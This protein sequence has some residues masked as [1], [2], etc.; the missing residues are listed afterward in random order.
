M[1]G[2][3]MADS[4]MIGD[5]PA[6]PGRGPSRRAMLRMAI[7][8]L[9]GVSANAFA[10]A[11]PAAA[12]D[13]QPTYPISGEAVTTAER[14][15]AF[16]YDLTGLSAADLQKVAQYDQF[17]YGRW[18]FGAPLPVVARAD[19]LPGG[20]AL[21]MPR[22]KTKLLRFFTFTDVHITDKE[23]PNQL[24]DLQRV[25]PAAHA[26]TS[27]YSPVMLY[28]TQVLDA[29]VQTVNAL[30]QEAPFDFGIV[31]GDVCNSASYKELRWFIDVM[32]GKKITPSSG[33]HAGAETVDYQMAFNAAG[34][35]RSIPWYQVLGNHDHFYI[36]SIPVDARPE[37]GIRESYVADT[38]WAVGDIL[39][40]DL[41]GFP[42]LFSA[43]NLAKGPRIYPGVV[44]GTSPD[45][46][47]IHAGSTEDAAFSGT[48][49]KVTPDPERRHIDRTG[50]MA[51][52]FN[53]E[54]GPRGHGFHL[55][56]QSG[57]AAAEDGFACYSF[58]PDP[59]IPLKVIVLGDTQREDD[60]SLD[61]HGHGYLDRTRWAW[62]KTELEQGQA[63]DQLMIVAAHIP[64]GVSGIGSETEWWAETAGIAPELRNAVSLQE[65]VSAL[66]AAPN[67]IAWISGHRHLNTV[68]AFVS[69]DASR[70]EMGFWQVETS[71][72]R[73]FPQQFRT[74]DILLNDD[75]TISI[76]TLNVDPAVAEGSP[77]ATSRSR[78]V[79]VQQIV[80]NDLRVNIP[81]AMTL[82]GAETVPLPTMDP[83]RPQDGKPDPSIRFTD[84]S[85]ASPPVPYHAS[86]NGELIK[87]LKPAM[88]ARLKAMFL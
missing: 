73:D 88:A 14:M 24:I 61:I 8:L 60:G 59:R 83:S 51:E 49:P 33:S 12:A 76:L 64:I 46:A 23:A 62:L 81:N 66:N 31:L 28:S 25:E 22:N 86:Y 16:P 80:R 30:H 2:A 39:N 38:V 34:L 27:V 42:V 85:T 84:L 56:D 74:F 26:N 9:G 57:P 21:A 65:L 43:E 47:I 52:F 45:G 29:A 37:L 18:T 71:S 63:N 3:H 53:S 41:K 48:P 78:A 36:G 75:G 7:G 17:G 13:A 69:P 87:P 6:V 4:R 44:D 79:A 10:A 77:A 32:D 72:L 54:S 15:I 35:D 11:W 40:P 1:E 68:K 70:P 82:G 50:W 19:L 20:A 58:V 55:I 67:L 5:L